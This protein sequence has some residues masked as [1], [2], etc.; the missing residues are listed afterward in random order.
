M[1]VNYSSIITVHRSGKHVHVPP[2]GRMRSWMRLA[3]NNV[4]DD[5][6]QLEEVTGAE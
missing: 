5:L 6:I 2:S 3:C 4:P 1:S